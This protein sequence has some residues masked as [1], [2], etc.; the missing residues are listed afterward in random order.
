[1]QRSMEIWPCFHLV[2]NTAI[3]TI[4]CTRH[5]SCVAV[6]CTNICRD[7]MAR[8]EIT[9]KEISIAIESK[10]IYPMWERPF[11]NL[12]V[13]REDRMSWLRHGD[14]S[15]FLD[16]WSN[17]PD[18]SHNYATL[19]PNQLAHVRVFLWFSTGRFHPYLSGLLHC[20]WGNHTIA[21]VPVK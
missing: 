5:G 11:A 13:P 19:Y 9:T 4:V 6:A 3:A 21:P 10:A 12:W 8:N 18:T 17:V 16:S 14:T 1:M 7:M 20:H 15:Y 2:S